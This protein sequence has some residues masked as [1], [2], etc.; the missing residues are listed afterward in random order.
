MSWFHWQWLRPPSQLAKH[1]GCLPSTRMPRYQHPAAARAGARQGLVPQLHCFP[2][3]QHRCRDRG[4]PLLP[5]RQRPATPAAP[6]R[7]RQLLPHHLPRCCCCCSPCCCCCSRGLWVPTQPLLVSPPWRRTAAGSGGAA[8]PLPTR[9][10]GCR[11]SQSRRRLRP[12]RPA[13]LAAVPQPLLLLMKKKKSKGERREELLLLL[14]PDW[15]PGQERPHA[16]P[17]AAWAWAGSRARWCR[18]R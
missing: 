8:A 12:P 7:Q 5:A 9:V 3:Q 14:L 18:R 2:P 13:G 4:L 16:P 10:Q 17:R 1:Q 15:R 6:A 11:L